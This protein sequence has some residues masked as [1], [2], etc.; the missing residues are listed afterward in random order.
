MEIALQKFGE[1][2]GVT[3]VNEKQWQNILDLVNKAIKAKDH[4]LPE[5]KK[6]AEASAQLYAVKVAWRNEVMH[7]KQTYTK[8]EAE[9]IFRNTKIFARELVD[10]L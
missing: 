2:L 3:L 8:E 4:R 6:M 7:P 9:N 10:V 5:T 1:A